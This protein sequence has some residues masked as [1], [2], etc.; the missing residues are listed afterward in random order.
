MVLES[1]LYLCIAQLCIIRA[2]II[3][4]KSLVFNHSS[5]EQDIIALLFERYTLIITTWLLQNRL[6]RR[7][8][9][10]MHSFEMNRFNLMFQ[11]ITVTSIPSYKPENLKLSAVDVWS[12]LTLVLENV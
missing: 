7:S 8:S 5:D 11:Q 12:G 3:T 2:I 6:R 4:L 1:K 10:E 9:T